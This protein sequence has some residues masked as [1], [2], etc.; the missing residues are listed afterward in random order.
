[1]R[2]ELLEIA[3]LLPPPPSFDPTEPKKDE[4]VGEKRKVGNGLGGDRGK[5]VP[6]WMRLGGKN[7]SEFEEI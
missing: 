2:S 1:L 5:V 4:K 6:S 3:S 7:A